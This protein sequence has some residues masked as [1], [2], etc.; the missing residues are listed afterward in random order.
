MKSIKIQPIKKQDYETILD[1][2]TRAYV[3]MWEKWEKE[4][5]REFVYFLLKRK[6]KV[7]FVL[8]NTIIWGFIAEVKPRY[9]WNMLFDPELVIDSEYQKQWYGTILLKKVLKVVEKKYKVKTLVWFTFK[10]SFHI[11]RYKKLWINP[12]NDRQMLYWDIKDII[13][14]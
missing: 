7:K 8:D 6:I 12:S 9:E 2:Y 14:K 1:I 3:A 11:H 13:K 10:N 4:Q 5:I